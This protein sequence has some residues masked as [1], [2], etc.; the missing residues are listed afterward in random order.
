MR[1]AFGTVPVLL[2]TAVFLSS[3]VWAPPL[4]RSL[5]CREN[6]APSDAIFVEN[7]DPSYL[8]FERAAIVQR[9]KLSAKVLVP[10]QASAHDPHRA[11]P[12]SAA[13]AELMARFAR[14]QNVEI[15][16]LRE[17]EPYTLNAAYQLRRYLVEKRLRSI[18]VVA[19]AFRSQRS[20]LVYEAV[21]L[22]A[23]IAVHCVP[24]FGPHTPDNW[25]SSWH[26]IATVSQ[27]LVKLQFYRFHVLRTV[28]GASSLDSQAGVAL[29]GRRD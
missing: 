23:G 20:S 8:L 24:V 4:A 27:Q 7:F 2:L 6:L 12:V 22:P 18:I 17:I 10:A 28:I 3:G 16:S 5:V 14:L 26:G 21:L 1:W 25:A 13:V 15:I 29:R 9:A 19:P 11:L